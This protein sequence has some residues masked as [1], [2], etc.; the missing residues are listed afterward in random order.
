MKTMPN[1]DRKEIERI[2][3]EALKRRT[4]VFYAIYGVK[5]SVQRRMQK[6]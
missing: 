3:R 4:D 5:S 2:I 1:H 6:L